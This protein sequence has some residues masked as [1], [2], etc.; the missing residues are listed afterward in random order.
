MTRVGFV[1]QPSQALRATSPLPARIPAGVAL[2]DCAVGLPPAVFRWS[3]QAVAGMWDQKIRQ[4]SGEYAAVCLV[5]AAA[6]VSPELVS[7]AAPNSGS[8]GGG[9]AVVVGAGVV[10][11]GVV[12]SGV[13]DGG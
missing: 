10:G 5:R 12:G 11:S 9:G 2:N 3:A 1:K 13:G 8:G 4:I 6:K 7:T